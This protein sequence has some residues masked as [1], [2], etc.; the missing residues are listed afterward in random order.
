MNKDKEREEFINNA[1]NASN[2]ITTYANRN[3]APDVYAAAIF[4][5]VCN[6]VKSNGYDLDYAIKTLKA[7][8]MANGFDE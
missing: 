5:C 6:H 1:Y 2:I 7:T 4:L 3:W 8:W